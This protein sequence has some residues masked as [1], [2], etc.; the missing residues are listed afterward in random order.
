MLE[1]IVNL[2]L[3][4]VLGSRSY[5]HIQFDFLMKTDDDCFIRLD[6]IAA[7][8]RNRDLPDNAWLGG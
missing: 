6:Q 1:A 8:L 2:L 7:E 5:Q 4:L 3:K